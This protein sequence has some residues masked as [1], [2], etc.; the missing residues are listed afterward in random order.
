MVLGFVIIPLLIVAIPVSRAFRPLDAAFV[1]E[2]ADAHALVLTPTNRPLVEYYLATARKLRTLGAVAGILLPP[3]FTWSLGLDNPRV[4]GFWALPG[5][6]IGAA[7]A[8][9]RLN[10]PLGRQRAASLAPRRLGDY[11]PRRLLRAQRVA[12]VFSAL[13]AL[14]ALL[15]Q[16][17]DLDTNAGAVIVA[18][19]VGAA[20]AIAL[21]LVERHIVARPQ[22]VVAPDL[23]AADDAIRSQSIHSVA[24]SGLAIVILCLVSVGLALAEG[25]D[26]PLRSVLLVVLFLFAWVGALGAWLYYGHRAWRVPRSPAAGL[27]A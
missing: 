5:Y 1:R 20:L 6:L 15:T 7:Y 4:S 26:E 21:E 19:G 14:A 9:L 12:G 27:R 13:G 10:R 25:L 3:L 18:G 2:W 16:A 23:V 11:L 17:D 22:P 8:E 24:G